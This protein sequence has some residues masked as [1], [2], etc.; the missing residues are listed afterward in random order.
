MMP[1]LFTSIPLSAPS[2]QFATRSWKLPL[3]LSASPATVAVMPWSRQQYDMST[4]FVYLPSDAHPSSEPDV[5]SNVE[6]L[7]RG[8][9]KKR[10]RR[11]FVVRKSRWSDRNVRGE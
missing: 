11:V 7:K 3:R 6:Y 1:F 2:S 8:E 9:K 5:Q 4:H 10:A